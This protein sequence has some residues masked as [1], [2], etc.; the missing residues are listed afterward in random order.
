MLPKHLHM[1]RPQIT[2]YFDFDYFC[3][4]IYNGIDLTYAGMAKLGGRPGHSAHF[5]ATVKLQV[6]DDSL[7]AACHMEE[8]DLDLDQKDEADPYDYKPIFALHR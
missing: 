8:C 5:A 6:C 7:L 4:Q 1:I 2:K 3:F